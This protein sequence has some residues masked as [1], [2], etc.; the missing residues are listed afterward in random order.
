MTLLH[1]DKAEHVNEKFSSPFFCSYVFNAQTKPCFV[2][3][4]SLFELKCLCVNALVESVCTSAG[5]EKAHEFSGT[6]PF[7]ALLHKIQE[8]RTQLSGW[9]LCNEC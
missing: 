5:R 8:S 3:L 7:H 9:K 6:Q 4:M 2:D 1:K